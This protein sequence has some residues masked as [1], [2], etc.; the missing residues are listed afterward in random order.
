M[1]FSASKLT[2]KVNLAETEKAQVQLEMNELREK[3]GSLKQK[4]DDAIVDSRLMVN[5]E[6]HIDALSVVKQWVT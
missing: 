6:E 1:H 4:Y 2:Q 3:L 5:R